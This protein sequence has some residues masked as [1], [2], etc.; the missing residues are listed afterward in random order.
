MA[1][2]IEKKGKTREKCFQKITYHHY[3][4]W[5]FHA[6]DGFATATISSV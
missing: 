4:M 5:L 6:D 1:M 2:M 3:F